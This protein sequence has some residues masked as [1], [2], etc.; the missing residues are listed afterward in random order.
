MAINFNFYDDFCVDLHFT[1]ILPK[2]NII[3]TE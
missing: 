2:N 1:Q 3:P